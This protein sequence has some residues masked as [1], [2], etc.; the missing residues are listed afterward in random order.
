MASSESLSPPDSLRNQTNQER[1]GGRTKLAEGREE[2]RRE[3]QETTP[4]PLTEAMTGASPA[5]RLIDLG[6]DRL[7]MC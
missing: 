2:R 3:E 5:Q 6:S 7:W 4:A 1:R